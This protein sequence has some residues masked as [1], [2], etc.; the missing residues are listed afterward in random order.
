LARQDQN[1][2]NRRLAGG[3]ELY[4]VLVGDLMN[5]ALLFGYVIG[6]V[7]MFVV[8]GCFG[9]ASH[10]PEVVTNGAAHLYQGV[11]SANFLIPLSILGTALGVTVA[12]MGSA[13][14]GLPAVLGSLTALVMTL[15]MARFAHLIATAGVL[16][17]AAGLVYLVVSHI[18]GLK[19]ALSEFEGKIK[20]TEQDVLKRVGSPLA[21]SSAS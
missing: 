11:N 14:I 17:A 16:T 21:S 18:K 4:V 15:V 8:P 1:G 20:D 3:G 12:F 9:V 19:E 2:S 5:R 7:L 6:S 13:K 10:V